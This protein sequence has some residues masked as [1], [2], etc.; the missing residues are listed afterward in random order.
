MRLTT[1]AG[2]VAY[3]LVW[4]AEHALETAFLAFMPWT[5]ISARAQTT[6][7]SRMRESLQNPK[8]ESKLGHL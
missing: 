8:K 5:R 6:E 1:S 4:T 2:A 7:Y 3:D